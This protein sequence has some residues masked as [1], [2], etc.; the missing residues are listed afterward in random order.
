MSFGLQDVIRMA[1]PPPVSAA[2]AAVV[3]VPDSPLVRA[4]SMDAPAL[5][6]VSGGRM[7]EGSWNTDELTESGAAASESGAGAVETVPC[8]AQCGAD[9]TER[10]ATRSA[11][12]FC[13][14]C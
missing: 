1:P 5:V 4:G 7:P 13:T 8:W 6:P 2:S 9:G 12:R 11:A 3:P 14:G 10:E